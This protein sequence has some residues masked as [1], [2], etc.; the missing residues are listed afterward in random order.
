MTCWRSCGA[1]RDFPIVTEAYRVCLQ[2]VLD[3][4]HLEEVLGAVAAGMI[5]VSVVH[6]AVPSPIAND[7][8]F[9]FANTYVYEWDAPKAERDL[10]TLGLPGDVLDCVLAE[11]E[12]LKRPPAPGGRERD[13]R[14]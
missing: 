3:L 1:W 5:E 10:Q 14:R 9:Y 6:R 4:P 13:N 11:R 12:D 8:L 2:D 7:L